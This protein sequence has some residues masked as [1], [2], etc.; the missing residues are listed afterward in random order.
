L[1]V[2]GSRPLDDAIAASNGLLKFRIHAMG[3]CI[4]QIALWRD[5]E[6]CA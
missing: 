1:R 2:G 6:A 3:F 4:G 5:R